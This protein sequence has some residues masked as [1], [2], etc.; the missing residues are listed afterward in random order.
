MRILL[1]VP[2]DSVSSVLEAL[3]TARGIEVVTETNG[4]RVVELCAEA[5]P[6]GV[7]VAVD[8]TGAHD[9]VEVC[10]LLKQAS[11]RLPVI[12]IGPSSDEDVRARALEA[13]ATGYYGVPV[14]PTALVKELES[15]RPRS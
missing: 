7:V 9:G 1:A 15:I 2:S 13:G 14:S 12:V 11:T 6:D 3:L 10:R 4:A 8:V 5:E